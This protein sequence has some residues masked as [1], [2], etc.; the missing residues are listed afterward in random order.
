LDSWIVGYHGLLDIIA[1]F[2][3]EGYKNRKVFGYKSTY[4]KKIIEF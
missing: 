1:G 2:T 4:P 3:R